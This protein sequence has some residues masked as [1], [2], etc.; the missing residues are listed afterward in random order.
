MPKIECSSRLL[1]DLLGVQPDMAELERLLP[2]A[3]A[4]L[5][6]IDEDGATISFELNDTN[7]PDLWSTVGLAR[8]LRSW[9]DG[10][11]TQYD[12]TSDASDEGYVIEVDPKLEH[13]R[14]I[15]AGFD[16]QGPQLSDA[17][18][19]ELIQSQ[20]KLCW[21]YGRK[22]R[23]IS[24]GIYRS[25]RIRWPVRYSAV[26]P[27][28]TAF[29]PLDMERSMNLREILREH[30][31]GREYGAIVADMSLFPYLTDADGRV[32]SF[33]PIINSADIGAV[34]VGDQRLFIEL[35]GDN[36]YS[37]CTACAVVACD[38]CDLGF[39]I[40]PV[41]VQYP[42]DTPLGRAL[43]TPSYFQS[44]I[45]L[46]LKYA[47]RLLGRPI[48]ADHAESALRRMGVR[49]HQRG[50]TLRAAPPIYRNDFLHA[51][52]VVEDIMIGAG[53]DTFK[54]R[55]PTDFTVGR[56]SDREH[57]SRRV[58]SVMVGLGF[59]EMIFSYLGSRH[60]L[61]ERI[62]PEEQW[63]QAE[64]ELTRI[65][66]PLSQNYEYVRNSTLANLLKSES[67]SANAVFPH[68]IFEIGKQVRRKNE[69]LR[70]LDCLGFLLAAASGSNF[71]EA[72]SFIAALMYY[73]GREYELSESGDARYISGR[74]AEILYRGEKIGL[75][76]ELH[77]AIL[78]KWTIQVP[79]IAGEIDLDMLVET[80]ENDND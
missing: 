69:I 25:D 23:A 76:G 29:V 20:E 4:E 55:I 30:P 42:Y 9:R 73:L 5:D 57:W 43:V 16:A 6:G 18:L 63:E 19:R 48:N 44:G 77:P 1:F 21:N 26:D 39:R 80:G 70:T 22:R 52:D 75:F 50:G 53:I 56:L 35:T 59:Q 11:S 31:K 46:D 36:I 32:L 33:P 72:N 78:E 45:E 34:Q 27:A 17:L 66:N 2:A 14:P 37:I 41:R 12:F 65:A 58:K 74:A 54:P 40:T 8:Q 68:R 60:D 10:H 15:I 7:R 24:M 64:R 3:K 71:N 62:Y 47:S 51:V 38:L 67:S 28:T 61:V 79:C 13:I 49:V